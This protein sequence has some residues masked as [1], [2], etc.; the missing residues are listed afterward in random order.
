MKWAV[1]FSAAEVVEAK[2]K[3]NKIRLMVHV[4]FMT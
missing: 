2:A 4:C 1:R 3:V